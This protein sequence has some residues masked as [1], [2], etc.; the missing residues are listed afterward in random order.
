M[1]I[2]TKRYWAYFISTGSL[3][4][5]EKRFASISNVHMAHYAYTGIYCNAFSIIRTVLTERKVWLNVAIRLRAK[6][7]ACFQSSVI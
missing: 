7:C 5:Y 1:E 2:Q 6:N 4:F 3:E